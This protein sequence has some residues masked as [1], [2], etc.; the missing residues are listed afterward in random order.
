MHAATG[1]DAPA[2]GRGRTSKDE[3]GAEAAAC[4]G[5]ADDEGA[6]VGAGVGVGTGAG[7]GAGEGDDESGATASSTAGEHAPSQAL[8]PPRF[9][10]MLLY[11]YDFAP[12]SANATRMDVRPATRPDRRAYRRASRRGGSNGDEWRQGAWWVRRKVRTYLPAVELANPSLQS[13]LR[14]AGWDAEARYRCGLRL[15]RLVGYAAAAT[16]SA[17]GACTADGCLAY[18]SLAAVR[19]ACAA[20]GVHGCEGVAL[21]AP[22]PPPPPLP[23]PPPPPRG[24]GKAGRSSPATSPSPPRPSATPLHFETRMSP[25]LFG[26]AAAKDAPPAAAKDA[27][28]ATAGPAPPAAAGPALVY[29]ERSTLPEVPCHTGTSSSRMQRVLEWARAYDRDLVLALLGLALFGGSLWG[30]MARAVRLAA[31][32]VLGAA[33]RARWLLRSR[34]VSKQKIS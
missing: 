3:G 6:G 9:L 19:A 30:P 28:P 10:R 29:W 11:H 12:P 1:T 2:T 26:A 33:R 4:E 14:S 25:P 15:R 24:R 27:L 13:F 18:E 17:M 8:G 22:S 5:E 23:P 7:A 16:P 21:V 34:S 20:L 32:L 31:S